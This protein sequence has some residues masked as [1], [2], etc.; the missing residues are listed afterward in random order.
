MNLDIYRIGCSKNVYGTFVNSNDIFLCKKHW[1]IIERVVCQSSVELPTSE[2]E[3]IQAIYVIYEYGY[4]IRYEI[5]IELYQKYN[6]QYIFFDRV[7][8]RVLLGFVPML[9][10]CPV[11]LLITRKESFCKG[12]LCCSKLSQEFSVYEYSN[13]FRTLCVYAWLYWIEINVNVITMRNV[14]LLLIT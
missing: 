6:I 1:L 13:I 10:D 5:Y 7:L 11:F 9:C 14:N 12:K 2:H 8:L 3:Q 4:F